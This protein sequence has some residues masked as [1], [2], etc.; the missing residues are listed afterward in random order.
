MFSSQ[1]FR[2]KFRRNR[3]H[4]WIFLSKNPSLIQ[5]RVR[6]PPQILK[7]DSSQDEKSHNSDEEV[8]ADIEENKTNSNLQRDEYEDSHTENSKQFDPNINMSEASYKKDN[9][10]I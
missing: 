3:L 9:K 5:Y 1:Y 2:R 6:T 7:E 8:K 10:F 4:L